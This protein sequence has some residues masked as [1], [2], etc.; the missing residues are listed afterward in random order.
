M[1]IA[2]CTYMYVHV[3][4]IYI[5]V[6]YWSACPCIVECVLS[7]VGW[8]VALLH[9]LR[10]PAYEVSSCCMCIHRIQEICSDYRRFLHFRVN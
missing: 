4:I 3:C 8:P 10:F 5:H 7:L 2:T 6:M 1:N 9:D